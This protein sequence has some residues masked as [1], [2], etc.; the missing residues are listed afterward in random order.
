MGK[1][2]KTKNK[3]VSGKPRQ[4]ALNEVKNFKSLLDIGSGLGKSMN[5]L[6]SRLAKQPAKGVVPKA[7]STKVK[8]GNI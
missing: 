8:T 6:S 4:V 5:S 1:A 7:A 2:K 3:N